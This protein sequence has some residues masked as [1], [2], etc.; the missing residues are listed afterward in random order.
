MIKEY[1]DLNLTNPYMSM[2]TPNQQND[3]DQTLTDVPMFE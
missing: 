2:F 1:P 3:T